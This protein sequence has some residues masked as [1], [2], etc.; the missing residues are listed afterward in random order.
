[1]M[2]LLASGFDLTA[3]FLSSAFFFKDLRLQFVQLYCHI[4]TIDLQI[5]LNTLKVRQ[6]MIK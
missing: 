6:I 1:M 3:A 5:S 2:I 4:V